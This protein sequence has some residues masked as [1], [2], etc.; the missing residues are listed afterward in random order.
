MKIKC[1]VIDD[2]PLALQLLEKHV[3]KI[4]QL[5][6]VATASNALKAFEIINT[7]HV[8][9]MF[10]DI[11]MPTLSG[12]DFLRSLKNPPKTIITTA[13]RGFAIEGFE[14]EV[15]DYLLKP[16]TFERF[17]KSLDKFLR[18]HNPKRELERKIPKGD[19]IILKSGAKNHK[20]NIT[21]VLYIESLKDYIKVHTL[22]GKSIM[23]KYKI[24]DMQQA[25]SNHEF[26][27]VHR[28][29]IINTRKIS[30]FTSNDIDMNG[31]E[32]PI[33]GSYKKDVDEFLQQLKNH[34]SN[35]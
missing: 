19:Y 32:I 25:L 6:I 18:N 1:L 21:E 9:L 13:Y 35:N 24:S 12:L 15:I 26:L 14:L 7:E 2:E 11:K 28:S 4:E 23:S 10:L 34:T 33:G 22:S 17:L 31:I 8:D 20:V 30:A 3:S 5:E 16:I 27:R 29:Y